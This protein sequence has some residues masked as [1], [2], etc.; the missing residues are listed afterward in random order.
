MK[1]KPVVKTTDISNPEQQMDISTREAIT[2]APKR[3]RDDGDVARAE[4]AALRQRIRAG[5]NAIGEDPRPKD[6]P[7]CKECFQRGW[8]AAMRHLSK[9]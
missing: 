8:L 7:A 3:E 1:G 6:P 4:L 5:L 9:D 2:Q